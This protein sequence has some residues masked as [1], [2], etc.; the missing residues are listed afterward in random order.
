MDGAGQV[1]GDDFCL[2]EDALRDRPPHGLRPQSALRQ[3]Q[4]VFG[5]D[6]STALGS[7][8]VGHDLILD[9][10]GAAAHRHSGGQNA[11]CIGVDDRDLSLRA[12]LSRVVDLGTFDGDDAV[13]EVEIE[14]GEIDALMRIHRSRMGARVGTR[15]VDSAQ[16]SA[17]A[18]LDQAELSTAGTA[19]IGQVG[20][21]LVFG[22]EPSGWSCPQQLRLHEVV[23]D[24]GR[25]VREVHEVG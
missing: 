8:P 14:D 12:R 17:G 11:L 23:D 18:R 20:G 13:L 5:D 24:L 21:R 15:F 22:P 4:F 10:D 3:V 2:V 7:H 9:V 1:A 16:Q 19:D 6:R 25:I